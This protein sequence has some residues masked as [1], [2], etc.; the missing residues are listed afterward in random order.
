MNDEDQKLCPCGCPAIDSPSTNMCAHCLKGKPCP[1]AK[2]ENVS[3]DP[4][5]AVVSLQEKENAGAMKYGSK[6]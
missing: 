1:K 5:T 6:K 2:K 4:R 3:T